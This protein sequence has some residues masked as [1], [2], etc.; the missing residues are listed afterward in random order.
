MRSR[1][2]LKKATFTNEDYQPLR[3]FYT[4]VV[5]KQAEQI[6]FKKIQ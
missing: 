5:K 1:V 2:Q 6:V 3:E 4:Y